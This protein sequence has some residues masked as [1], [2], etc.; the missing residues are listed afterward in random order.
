[1]E[2]IEGEDLGLAA[3]GVM[4]EEAQGKG[5]PPPSPKNQRTAQADLVNGY[6]ASWAK[7]KG[8]S[9]NSKGTHKEVW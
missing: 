1:V 3:E 8:G 2:G 5:V 6:Q 9:I 7:M 4:W